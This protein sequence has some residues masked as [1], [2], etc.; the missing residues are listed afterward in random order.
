[1]RYFEQ[2]L[3]PLPNDRPLHLKIFYPLETLLMT[4]QDLGKERMDSP[5]I[6]SLLGIDFLGNITC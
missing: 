2:N 6:Q 5:A 1:M 3:L 4:Q